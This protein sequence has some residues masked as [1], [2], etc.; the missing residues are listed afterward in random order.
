MKVVRQGAEEQLQRA[1][2]GTPRRLRERRVAPVEFA[3]VHGPVLTTGP[4][5]PIQAL[6][7]I[8]WNAYI[9]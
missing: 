5:L 8:V 7:P 2:Q 4:S 1:L 9:H 6:P 3:P